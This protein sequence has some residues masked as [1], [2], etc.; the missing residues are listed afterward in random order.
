[1]TEGSEMSGR[2]NAYLYTSENG[3]LYVLYKI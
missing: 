1:M 3:S 2:H